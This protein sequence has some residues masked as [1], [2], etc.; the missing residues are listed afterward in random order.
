LY[1][2]PHSVASIVVEREWKGN[3]AVFFDR[4]YQPEEQSLREIDSHFHIMKRVSVEVLGSYRHM[5]RIASYPLPLRRLLWHIALK[6][7]GRMR[8]KY[9]GTFSIN[10][11]G[12]RYGQPTQSMTLQSM[13]WFYGR[14]RPDGSMPLHCFFDHRVIDGASVARMVSEIERTLNHDIVAE[15]HALS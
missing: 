2:H 3:A 14:I 9:F 13:S 8:T 12:G 4:I 11:V 15:L 10:S 7:S 5:I 6:G 1:E